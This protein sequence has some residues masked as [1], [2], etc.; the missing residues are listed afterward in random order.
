MKTTTDSEDC[1]KTSMCIT[2]DNKKIG[3]MEAKIQQIDEQWKE[4]I[5]R[6]FA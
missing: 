6:N 2:V 4:L 1:P 3:E 5:L